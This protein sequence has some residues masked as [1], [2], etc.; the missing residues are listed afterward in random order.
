[1][2]AI[3]QYAENTLEII[4]QQPL[5]EIRD[6]QGWLTRYGQ[7]W[8]TWSAREAKMTSRERLTGQQPTDMEVSKYRGGP[9]S[10]N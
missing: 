1:M 3:F 9:R 2:F 4:G 7:V 10:S 5:V 6:T 8:N